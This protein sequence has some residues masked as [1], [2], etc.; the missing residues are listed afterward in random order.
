MGSANLGTE[1]LRPFGESGRT[2]HTPGYPAV[3]G[4]RSTDVAV[5]WGA[6]AVEKLYVPL[7]LLSCYSPADPALFPPIPMFRRVELRLFGRR[8]ARLALPG[9]Q[10]A[11]TLRASAGLWRA[12]LRRAA[13][14]ATYWN[15][16]VFLGI[17]RVRSRAERPVAGPLPRPSPASARP[18]PRT[19]TAQTRTAQ[20]RTAQTRTA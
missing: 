14:P 6:K 3:T 12:N 19:R 10:V 15:L 1:P 5:A 4:T 7:N 2:I 11:R 17:G 18:T 13:E 16:A 20:T 8:L 9:P